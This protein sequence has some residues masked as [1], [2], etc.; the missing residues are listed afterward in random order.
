MSFISFDEPE[1][2]SFVDFTKPQEPE[3]KSSFLR[4]AADVP[5]GLVKGVVDLPGAV[6][7]VVD[8]F[9]GGS[10][11]AALD[12]I[13]KS[14]GEASDAL[15]LPSWVRPTQWSQGL[16]DS[17]S[18]ETKAALQGVETSAKEGQAEAKDSGEGAF[19]QILGSAKG[20]AKGILEN[21]S[22]VIA[23]AAENYGGMK[24]ISMGVAK[25][26]KPM[27]LA[28]DAQVSAGKMT[29]EAA[30]KILGDAAAKASAIGEGVLTVG[31][32][33]QSIQRA[34]PDADF[35]HR[36]AAIP[37]GVITGSITRGASKIPGLGDVEASMATASLGK[38]TGF[39]GSLPVRVGK[40]VLSEGFIE[41][42]P[43]SAQEQV[44]QN[45]GASKPW[46]EDVGSQA[47]QGAVSGGLLGG[48]M[49]GLHGASA[50]AKPA[51]PTPDLTPEIFNAP[52]VD[53]AINAA[54]RAIAESITQTTGADLFARQA[55]NP[56]QEA[57]NRPAEDVS[58][59]HLRAHETSLHLV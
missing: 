32:T 43:Q 19:G 16:R 36:L 53:S 51:E 46:Q 55:Q 35:I 4:R 23:L 28:L 8:T 1:K 38:S 12:P 7:G 10:A 39:A 22:S 15:G 45:I 37:A 6:T 33:G 52:D 24:A 31:Q 26:I 3:K 14:L 9:T 21:P 5:L 40:G 59:K 30:N 18:P 42:L 27:S 29:A 11:S 58:Y 17:Y 13:I 20:A 56:L 54:E 34:D 50:D 44:W 47:V 2:D 49:A 48:G 25:F 41:E 57:I